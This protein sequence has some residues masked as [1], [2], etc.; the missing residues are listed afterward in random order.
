MK[1][2]I[3]AGSLALCL[4]FVACENSNER[5]I[6]N[7]LTRLDN[8]FDSV[9]NNTRNYSRESWEEIKAEYNETMAKAEAE[10]TELSEETRQKLDEVKADYKSLE[11][12]YETNIRA[13]EARTT[14]HTSLFGDQ[15]V[16]NDRSFSWVTPANAYS[17]YERFVNTVKDNKDNYSREDWDEIKVLYEALDTRK[18]E[19]EKDLPSGDNMKIARKKVE[20]A[21]V[22]AVNRPFSKVE[23]NE[24]AKN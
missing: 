12:R 22:K 10:G 2:I 6:E 7:D 15:V 21:A 24:D 11:D 16:G 19:I 17:V 20:F 13:N 14:L 8:Y 18:N 4:A 5:A 9:G 1:K 23:E 3:S